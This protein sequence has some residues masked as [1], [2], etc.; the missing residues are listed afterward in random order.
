MPADTSDPPA[1]APD[2]PGSGNEQPQN[3]PPTTGPPPNENEHPTLVTICHQ[4]GSKKNPDVTITVA[5]EA[6][7]AHLALGDVLGACP[8]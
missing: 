8:G 4:T 2:P 5:S 3:P 1:A 7:D 6:V